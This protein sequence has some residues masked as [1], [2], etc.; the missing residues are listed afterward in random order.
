MDR[1]EKKRLRHH[2]GEQ[3][4]V[5]SARLTDDEAAFLGDFVDDY[6]AKYRGQT[7]T[8]SRSYTSWSSDGKYTRKETYTDS[9]TD[10]VGIRQK[11][12]YHDDNGQCGPSTTEVKDA[13]GILNWF[14]DH[15]S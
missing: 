15:G 12:E 7:D 6:N 9:F 11:Y 5:T 13:R 8:R 3:L 10:D 14:R 2:I 4:D 1:K